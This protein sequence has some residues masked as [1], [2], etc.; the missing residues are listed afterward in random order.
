MS[1]RVP[2]DGGGKA[3]DE[4]MEAARAG[5]MTAADVW[6]IDGPTWEA[7]W[8]A[9]C[10][11]CAAVPL[12]VWTCMSCGGIGESQSCPACGAEAMPGRWVEKEWADRQLAE[13]KA[14]IAKLQGALKLARSIA[15]CGER[16]YPGDE[17]IFDAALHGGLTD[18]P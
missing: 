14:H 17:A 7:A 5:A 10:A 11:Y 8:R 13:A 12:E 4:A 18:G 3:R 15:A 2:S 16:V 6:P 1:D 9:A